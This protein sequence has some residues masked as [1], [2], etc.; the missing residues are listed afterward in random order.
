MLEDT[1]LVITSLSL[2][3]YPSTLQVVMK[4]GALETAGKTTAAA[5]S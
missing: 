1:I 4:P 2:L 3:C 5:E